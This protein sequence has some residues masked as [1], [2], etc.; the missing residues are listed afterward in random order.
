[1]L[2]PNNVIDELIK[3]GVIKGRAKKIAEE[4]IDS[5]I[6]I[7]KEEF[8]NMCKKIEPLIDLIENSDKSNFY[9]G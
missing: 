5:Y 9:G 3:Q 8:I 2:S 4:S 6:C 7:K 1:M